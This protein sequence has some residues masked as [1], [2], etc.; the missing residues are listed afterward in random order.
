MKGLGLIGAGALI[1][2]TAAILGPAALAGDKPKN[3]DERAAI[4]RADL[5]GVNFIENCRFSHQAPDDPIVFFGKPGASH[6]HTFV[7]NRTTNASSTFGSLRSGGD[8]VHA[9]G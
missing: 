6:Q 2:V 4:S 1:L 5:R 7:G 8:D 9:S 3:G